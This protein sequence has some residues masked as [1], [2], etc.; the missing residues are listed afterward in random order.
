LE[1]SFIHYKKKIQN[2][3]IC[4]KKKAVG[5]IVGLWRPPDV[6]F[7]HQKRRSTATNAT[8]L[9]ENCVKPLNERD[10]DD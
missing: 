9:L 10:Q 7:S 8:E 1:T 5:V 4:K 6:N 3:V 2:W